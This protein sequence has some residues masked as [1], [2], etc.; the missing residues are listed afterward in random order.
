MPLNLSVEKM[1]NVAGGAS[2]IFLNTGLYMKNKVTR[3]GG[4]GDSP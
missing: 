2:L 3:S 1:L 4:A